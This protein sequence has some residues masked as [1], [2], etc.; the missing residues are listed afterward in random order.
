[1]TDRK[2]AE[3]VQ[4]WL[5]QLLTDPWISPTIAAG[6]LT[7]DTLDDIKE[8]W[9]LYETQIKLGV[10]FTLIGIKKNSLAEMSTKIEE[11]ITLGVEDPDEWV[12]LIAQTF[13]GFT[14]SGR[15]NLE[16]QVFVERCTQPLSDLKDSLQKHGV[17]FHP[18]VFGYLNSQVVKS[19]QV[20]EGSKPVK[21]HF[22]V[23]GSQD[24]IHASRQEKLKAFV[25]TTN[26][27]PA[28]PAPGISM[29]RPPP[30]GAS[31]LFVNRRKSST[32]SFLRSS[33]PNK[34]PANAF[35]KGVVS[36]S[37]GGYQ[38]QQRIQ[39]LDLDEGSSIIKKQEET[40]LKR[41][42]DEQYEKE[43]KRLKRKTEA[44][45]KKQAEIEKKRE[46]E[47][48]REEKRAA[49]K[50][51]DEEARE[52]K[53]AAKAAAAAAAL[54]ASDEAADDPTERADDQYN[55]N[56]T[57]GP[58][59]DNPLGTPAL[60][61]SPPIVNSPPEALPPQA[62]PSISPQLQQTQLAVLQNTNALNEEDRQR[63][64]DFLCGKPVAMP[65]N[66]SGETYQIVMN[67]E[68]KFDNRTSRTVL[69]HIV[70]E[71][72]LSNGQ[73]RKLRRKKTVN[74]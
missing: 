54:T 8:R 26:P 4:E 18:R 5:S 64:I 19:L 30:A 70:F 39:L 67:E 28:G 60:P 29:A 15:F 36:N 16:P 53:A 49:K 40:K 37:V 32:N 1:M 48:E 35:S 27:T 56:G 38:R 17:G 68:Q 55:P 47:K 24:A 13:Q 33:Q 63:I 59:D 3:G 52:A 66:H 7:N 31:S 34:G 14:A 61:E 58:D 74:S 69:E 9:N 71:M 43:L 22:K 45:E 25:T 65:P 50:R 23:K 51:M 57:E 20:T 6:E 2:R 72:N 10:M 73:W 42:Q 41:Q 11:L 62:E 21:T 12:R 46:R 44:E